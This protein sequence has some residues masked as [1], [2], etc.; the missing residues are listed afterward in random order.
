MNLSPS[1]LF[2]ERD[3]F[4][5]DPFKGKHRKKIMRKYLLFLGVVVSFAFVA[6]ANSAYIQKKVA[7]SLIP[8]G[9]IYYG[10]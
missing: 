1:S 9:R 8:G 10:F 6:A 3:I 2:S 4:G 5:N 7:M